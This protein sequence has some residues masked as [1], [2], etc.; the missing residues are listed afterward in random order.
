MKKFIEM[1]KAIKRLQ[2][3]YIWFPSFVQ[4]G[5]RLVVRDKDFVMANGFKFAVAV[6][7]TNGEQFIAVDDDFLKLSPETQEAIVYHEEAHLV[8][9]HRSSLRR[10]ILASLFGKVYANE[11][12]ADAYA[13]S[14]VGKGRMIHALQELYSV[15]PNKEIKRRI[16]IIQGA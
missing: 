2:Q 7:L 8:L 16:K 3:R 14:K 13:V 4:V 15:Y 11:V 12:E 6:E 9:K 1:R 5:E 10:R